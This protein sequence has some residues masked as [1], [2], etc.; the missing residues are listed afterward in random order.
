MIKVEVL[1]NLGIS[2]LLNESFYR[3]KNAKEYS[4]NVVK[5]EN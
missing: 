5:I 3:I 4:K 2:R 1:I